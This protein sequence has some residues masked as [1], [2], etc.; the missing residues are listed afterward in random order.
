[1]VR[2]RIR[3]RNL[4]A[5]Y[6]GRARRLA[7]EWSRRHPGIEAVLLS[8]GVARGYADENSEIDLTLFLTPAAYRDWVLRGS[9]P[10]P[11]GDSLWDG[12]GIDVHFTTI[13]AADRERWEPLRVWDASR[14][15]VLLDR[16]GGL[17]GLLRKKVRVP[18]DPRAL[19][20]DGIATD[21]YIWLAGNWIDR[22]DVVAG[23][24]LLN[25]AFDRFLA[26]LFAAQGEIPPFDKWRFHLSRSLRRLP[27]RYE[28]RV[29]EW[30]AIRGFTSRD[31][32][33]RMRAASG[34]LRWW[35]DAFP[36]VAVAVVWRDAL[37]ALRRRPVPLSE[38]RR[39]FGPTLLVSVPFCLVARVERG[40][41]R[42][43]RET[44]ARVL[45]GGDPRMHAY[46]LERLREAVAPR[47][48]SRGGRARTTG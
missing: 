31:I 21:W 48:P 27:P 11:E 4:Y 14:G 34:L 17:R 40:K 41:V 24:H 42:L 10:I 30:M 44:L 45:R 5:T 9:S 3:R 20:E 12:I 43:D 16:R 6:L 7:R 2:P 1:M 39:R 8:G 35:R 28:A 37:R 22:T 29:R 18:R 32:R 19:S 36:D 38:F 25:L 23:H 46:Q 13:R 33:R 47:R 26:G 15:K